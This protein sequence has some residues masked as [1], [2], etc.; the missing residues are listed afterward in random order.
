MYEATSREI[1]LALSGLTRTAEGWVGGALEVKIVLP[2]RLYSMYI[3][4]EV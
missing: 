4:T 1:C 2:N 3:D